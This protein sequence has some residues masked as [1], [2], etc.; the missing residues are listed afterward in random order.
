MV[1]DHEPRTSEEYIQKVEREAQ[2]MQGEHVPSHSELIK[3]YSN[4][5]NYYETLFKQAASIVVVLVAAF[6]VVRIAYSKDH[7]HY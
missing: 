3:K 2:R 7:S 6:I 4:Q 1:D 5:R